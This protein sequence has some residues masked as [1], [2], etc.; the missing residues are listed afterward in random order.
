MHHITIVC[1]HFIQKIAHSD[2]FIS[3]PF[4]DNLDSFPA[5]ISIY[6]DIGYCFTLIVLRNIAVMFYV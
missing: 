2:I 3:L 1:L 4:S 5:D 6:I